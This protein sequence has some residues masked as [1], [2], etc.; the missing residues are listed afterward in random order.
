[1]YYVRVAAQQAAQ[2]AL[3]GLTLPNPGVDYYGRKKRE[4]D[5]VWKIYE[6]LITRHMFDSLFS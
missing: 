3:G 4:N 1:M 5:H 2:H 6:V